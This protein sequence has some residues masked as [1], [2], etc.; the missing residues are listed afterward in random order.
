M[1]GKRKALLPFG[2]KPLIV[3]QLE[4]MGKLCEECIVVTDDPKPY[5]P[6]VDRS[7]RIITDFYEGCGP[8]GGLHA[9]L[10]LAKHSS[11]WA[12][13]CDMPFISSHA[14]R[15]LLERKRDG[16]DA[17]VPLAGGRPHPLHGIY[18]RTVAPQIEALLQQGE[19]D[20]SSL[21]KPLF[22]SEIGEKLL[23][24]N[25]IDTLCVAAIKTPDDY[26]TLLQREEQADDD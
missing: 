6:I 13:G 2:G 17:V 12:V 10:S 9:A 16:F 20:V 23:A 18:D 5:L 22:W 1:G 25:G 4:R 24:E 15:L 14:A 7:V 26:E 21:L 19:T 8:L 11:V 3:R